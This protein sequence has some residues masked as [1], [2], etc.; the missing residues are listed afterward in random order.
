MPAPDARAAALHDAA[1]K[2]ALEATLAARNALI[3]DVRAILEGWS[4]IVIERAPCGH[5]KVAGKRDGVSHAAVR[6]D[7]RGAAAHLRDWADR[8]GAELQDRSEAVPPPADPRQTDEFPNL[9]LDCAISAVFDDPPPGDDGDA[10]EQAAL[11][12]LAEF[13]GDEDDPAADD[14]PPPAPH[15]VHGG[16]MI[17]RDVIAR[18]R[19][20]LAL[21]VDQAAAD[22]IAARN[23]SDAADTVRLGEL[24]NLLLMGL[25]TDE[26]RAVQARLQAMNTWARA[27]EE[28]ARQVKRSIADSDSAR[29]DSFDAAAILWPQPPE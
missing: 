13:G 12:A 17:E 1:A 6:E 26:Q 10:E 7:A 29:L 3:A 24:N 27:V 18:R 28:R 21:A 19:L 14:P 20:E 8:E 25:I 4:D 2:R 16:M 9:D 22:L 5:W 11:D 23:P 15:D